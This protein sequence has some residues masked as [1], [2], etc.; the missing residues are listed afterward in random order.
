MN[1]THTIS[2]Q[3]R[4]LVLAGLAELPLKFGIDLWMRLQREA[5]EQEAAARMEQAAQDEAKPK[6]PAK[7]KP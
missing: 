6:A 5:Q 7:A 2:P 4:Q 3:E 1:T